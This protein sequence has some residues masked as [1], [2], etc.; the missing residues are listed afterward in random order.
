ME[1]FPKNL[2]CNSPLSVDG[3][4]QLSWE[5]QMTFQENIFKKLLNG[6]KLLI[7]KASEISSDFRRLIDGWKGNIHV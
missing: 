1:K 2:S 6:K 3:A 4:F 5:K 7:Y